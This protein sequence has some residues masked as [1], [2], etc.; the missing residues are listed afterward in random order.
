MSGEMTSAQA[1]AWETVNSALA[2]VQ[3]HE[4]DKRRLADVTAQQAAAAAASASLAV[5]KTSAS[6]A[7]T[8]SRPADA[9]KAEVVKALAALPPD[10]AAS[11]QAVELRRLL[12]L[13]QT[14]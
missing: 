5:L 14:P 8:G 11:G 13:E 2:L 12:G 6:N 3:G 7:A 9:L 4:D 10:L 1:Q